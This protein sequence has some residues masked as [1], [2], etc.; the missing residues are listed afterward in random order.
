MTVPTLHSNGD[1]LLCHLSRLKSKNFILGK[2]P[3]ESLESIFNKLEN[4]PIYRYLAKYG[5]QTSLLKLGESIEDIPKDMCRACEKYLT[6]MESIENIV[7]L[8]SLIAKDDL[9]NIEVDFDSIMPIYQRFITE[10]GE[11][12]ENSTHL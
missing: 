2:Y 6:L 11:K 8:D 5:P 12:L 7:K 9:S 1:I 10:N 4:S 3:E